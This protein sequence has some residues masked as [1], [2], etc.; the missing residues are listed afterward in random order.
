MTRFHSSKPCHWN[1]P[2]PHTDASLRYMKHGPIQPLDYPPGFVRK[3]LLSGI[4]VM[5]LV[6]VFLAGL[7]VIVP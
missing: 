6:G 4:G 7:W 1:V 3:E 5:V 2:R